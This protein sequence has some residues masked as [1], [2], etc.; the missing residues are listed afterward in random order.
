MALTAEVT[1]LE[2]NRVRLDVAVPQDEVRK[3][4]DPALRKLAREGRI[5]GFPA[6]QVPPAVVLQRLGRDAVAEEMLRSALG[7]WYNDAVTESGLSPIDDPEF[8]LDSVPEEGELRFSATVP[9][10]PK[11]TLGEYRGLEVG[12]AEP[13]VPEGALEEQL[14]ALRIRG[15]RLSPV[16]RPAADQDYVVIDFEGASGGRKLR[17]VGARDYL[18][19]LGGGRLLP[20]F[21]EQLAGVPAGETVTFS[22]SYGDDDAR[23]EL[24]GRTVDYSV[25]VKQVQERVL[26]ELDDDFALEHTEFETMDEVRAD[27]E[28]RLAE[29]AEQ[30]VDELFRRMAIDAAV[31]NATVEVPQVMVDRRVGAI[32]NQ[33]AQQLPQGVSFEQY[34]AAT[35]QTIDGLIEE[36]RPDAEMAV[37]R[38][39]VIEAIADQEGVEISDEQVEEQVRSDAEATGRAVDR[40]LHELRH[41]G[42]WETLRADLRIK[43][44][45]ELLIEASKPIPMAQAEAREKLWTPEAERENAGAEDSTGK[46]W[47]P[48]DTR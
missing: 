29:A 16:E 27:I 35:N 42:G 7:D 13:E 33:T 19:Q 2:E 4:M 31:A 46:L 23:G 5:P 37:R 20:E 25:T 15:A 47:T 11:A 28:K 38:E 30:S 40:L 34:L 14:E 36:L 45:V 9:V 6:G 17:G 41:H 12:R 8:D 44:A 22:V 24:R 1:T 26:P 10:R 48:G 39:L 43:R 21:N 32:L 3:R 18:A